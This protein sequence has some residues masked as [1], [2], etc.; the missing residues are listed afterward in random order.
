M[1]LALGNVA[2]ISGPIE[3]PSITCVYTEGFLESSGH[4]KLKN[5]TGSVRQTFVVSFFFLEKR[6]LVL[7]GGFRVEQT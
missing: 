7:Y 3:T 2:P 6:Q 5:C 1:F 4:S